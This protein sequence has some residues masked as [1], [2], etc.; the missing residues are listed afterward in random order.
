M[1]VEAL[2]T[3]SLHCT[4]EERDYSPREGRVG[5]PFKA[6]IHIDYENRRALVRMDHW[7]ASGDMVSPILVT[8][9]EVDF[10]DGAFE[11][12]ALDNAAIDRTTGRF[13]MRLRT[14]RSPNYVDFVGTC[15]PGEPIQLP[16]RP[17]PRF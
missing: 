17:Q 6:Q 7:Q 5:E 15:E 2:A 4:V 11:L 10:L 3:V 8:D 12:A 9:G 16:A 1:F 13:S 14:L